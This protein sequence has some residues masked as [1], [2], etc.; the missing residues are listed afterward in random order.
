MYTTHS[1]L[2][3]SNMLLSIPPTTTLQHYTQSK[4]STPREK[5]EF[6]AVEVWLT[7]GSFT[8]P[9]GVAQAVPQGFAGVSKWRKMEAVELSFESNDEFET[10]GNSEIAGLSEY[11]RGSSRG[12]SHGSVPEGTGED[13]DE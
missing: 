5:H 7:S 6:G 10:T 1:K 4:K 8:L 2:V 11:V 3:Q 9:G 13:E 12:I